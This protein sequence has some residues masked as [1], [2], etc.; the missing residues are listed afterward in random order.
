M[1]N[2]D[3]SKVKIIVSIYKY[4]EDAFKGWGE[5]WVRW[6]KGDWKDLTT[7][8]CVLKLL[9]Q[10]YLISDVDNDIDVNIDVD[11]DIGVDIN[12]DINIDVSI[13]Y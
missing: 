2:P 7:Q 12:I 10:K 3:C 9:P 4:I 8:K 1:E 5:R 13:S 6:E 11:I